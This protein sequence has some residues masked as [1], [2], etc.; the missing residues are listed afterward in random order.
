MMEVWDVSV[1]VLIYGVAISLDVNGL[2][3]IERRKIEISGAEFKPYGGF[4]K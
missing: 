2:E 1:P 4:C 3:K